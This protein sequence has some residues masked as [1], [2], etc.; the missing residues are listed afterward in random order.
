MAPE[1]TATEPAE[2]YVVAAVS[3]RVGGDS[4]TVETSVI[5]TGDPWSLARVLLQDVSREAQA[6]VGTFDRDQ[7]HDAD[8]VVLYSI[9]KVDHRFAARGTTVSGKGIDLA[10]ILIRD[11]TDQAIA[12]VNAAATAAPDDRI[13]TQPVPTAARYSNLGDIID[14][15]HTRREALD[16]GVES[17]TFSRIW[18]A[19][20]HACWALRSFP[21]L[22]KAVERIGRHG[23]A[24]NISVELRD[25][26][27][28]P[29]FSS[30]FIAAVANGDEPD[31]AI[32]YRQIPAGA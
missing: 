6:V 11:L 1:T 15:L 24:V 19:I 23:R 22:R 27:S 31:R 26:I 5:T 3:V 10:G 2:R 16:K 18:V 20:P 9:D 21:E 29:T 4:Q 17:S 25:T 13:R 28:D 14:I 30:M 12:A 7:Q 32:T 8:V